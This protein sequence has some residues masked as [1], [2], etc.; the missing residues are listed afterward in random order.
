ML[1]IR[2]RWVCMNGWQKENNP[3]YQS[4]YLLE[5]EARPSTPLTQGSYQNGY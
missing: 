1:V 2:A 3:F 5:Y 4:G